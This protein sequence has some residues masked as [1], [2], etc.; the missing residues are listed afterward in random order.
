MMSDLSQSGKGVAIGNAVPESSKCEE[1]GTVYGSGWGS[2]WTSSA[3]RIQSAQNELRNKTA[4][5]G[6]NF[7]VMEVVTG[8]TTVA[9]SGR[10][11]RCVARPPNAVVANANVTQVPVP[12][13]VA[14]PSAE[15]RL[16]ELDELHQKG[17]L[18]DDEY[19]QRRKAIVDSL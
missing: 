4:K 1:L 5:L 13:A 6:G 9:I 19:Q 7:V 10:A 2:D 8:G 3:D 11:L 12:A 14:P 18:T 17:L 15:Q 16:R